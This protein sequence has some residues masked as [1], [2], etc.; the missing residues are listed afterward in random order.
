MP[1]KRQALILTEIVRIYNETG[2]P[3]GSKTLMNQLPIQI[4]SATIRNEMAALEEDGLIMKNHTSSGRLPSTSGYRYYLDYL[5]Q[6][7]V[8]S[9][10][11]FSTISQDFDRDF[12]EIDDIVKQ[13]ANIL[14]N[15]TNYTSISL[16]PE[17]INVTLTGFRLIPLGGDLVIAIL[18]TSMGSVESRVYRIPASISSDDLEKAVRIINDH[19]VGLPI[20]QVKQQLATEMPQLLTKYLH[21]PDG[22]LDMFGDVLRHAAAEHFYIGG[23]SNLL[24]SV[25]PDDLNRIK[26]IYQL[27]DKESVFPSLLDLRPNN[28]HQQ[29]TDKP[30]SVKL[31]DEFD[32]ALLN[33][34]GL[35]T[36]RYH[37]ADHGEGI[38]AILGPTSM[39]Y[40]QLIGLMQLFTDELVKKIYEYYNHFHD[41]S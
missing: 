32:N 28:D 38:I 34:Y 10:Q 4:S 8:V 26:S 27:L 35:I 1:T 37:V 22:F 19:L 6:P 18:A 2:Q 11:V 30:I 12:H 40:S 20:D 33:D 36:A 21:S 9:P 31:G 3:V 13:S 16:G 41:D 24:N 15:L 5:L 25:Q 39:P 14:S 23:R 29:S 7:S 17:T